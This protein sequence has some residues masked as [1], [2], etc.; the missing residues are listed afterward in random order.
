MARNKPE[1]IEFIK[2]NVGKISVG[3]MCRILDLKEYQIRYITDKKLGID[4][5]KVGKCRPD[6][7]DEEIAILSDPNK[8]DY[9]KAKL[10]PTRTD[11]AVRMQRRRLGFTSKPVEYNESSIY[12]GYKFIRQDKGYIGS[13]GRYAREHKLIIEKHI[14]RPLEK[15]EVIHHVNGRKLDNRIE[16]LC[17]C[18]GQTEHINIHNQLMEVVAELMDRDIVYFDFADR[19]YKVKA[20]IS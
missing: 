1:H 15:G 10:I 19:K 8:T 5:R 4:L 14:G 18:D 17:L 11:S 12:Q 7:N 2:N 16:N 3:E 9:E 6:W 20:S 13:Q